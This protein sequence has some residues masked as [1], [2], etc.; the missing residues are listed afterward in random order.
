MLIA[1]ALPIMKGFTK[2][3]GQKGY[4]EQTLGITYEGLSRV[5]QLSSL[6]VKPMTFDR[7]KSIKK[8]NTLKYRQQGE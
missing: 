4:S 8:L 5:K 6:I 1:R 7:L 2:P 3:G